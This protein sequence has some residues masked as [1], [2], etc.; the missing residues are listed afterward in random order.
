MRKDLF[1]DPLPQSDAE[2][3]A[4]FIES[5]RERRCD[6]FN[7]Y[8]ARVGVQ[9]VRRHV[10]ALVRAACERANLLPAGTQ[11]AAL[12]ASHGRLCRRWKM[13]EGTP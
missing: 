9:N 5:V 13:P 7:S 6:S 1:G 2:I 4:G 10:G 11:A 12:P 8:R 3:V